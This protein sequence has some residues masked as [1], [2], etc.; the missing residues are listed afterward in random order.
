MLE[1]FF[2]PCDLNTSERTW[3]FWWKATNQL[4]LHS[5]SV[6]FPN[7]SPMSVFIASMNSN[8]HLPL[9]V[10]SMLIHHC[11]L[12][13]LPPTSYK[14]ISTRPTP[15]YTSTFQRKM[16]SRLM[17]CKAT[18]AN[19]ELLKFWSLLQRGWWFSGKGDG[20]IQLT[21]AS[22]RFW[23]IQI[24]L[25]FFQTDASSKL[26]VPIV[27]ALNPMPELLN[28]STKTDLR[29]YPFLKAFF[30]H[31]WKLLNMKLRT[32]SREINLPIHLQGKSPSVS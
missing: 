31:G 29:S 26:Q 30:L 10:I 11:F 25:W 4:T 32:I 5:K 28:S 15:D 14:R 13:T 19:S 18:Y 21:W 12:G 1:Y 22:D 17:V 20:G 16:R 6:L 8:I 23:N 7:W 3:L 27:M 24:L 2:P 9:G